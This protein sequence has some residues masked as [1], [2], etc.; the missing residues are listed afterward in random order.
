M[1][2]LFSVSISCFI[3]FIDVSTS[4]GDIETQWI[5]DLCNDIEKESCISQQINILL[6][7]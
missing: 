3:D 6:A 4:H 2:I 7:S 5:L 1:L